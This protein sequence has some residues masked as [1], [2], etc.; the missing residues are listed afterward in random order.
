[1]ENNLNVMFFHGKTTDGYRFTIAGNINGN[2]LFMG[3]SICSDRDNFVKS[4][5]R[6]IATTRLLSEKNRSN[7][8]KTSFVIENEV[9]N[10]F[11]CFASL[12]AEHNFVPKKVLLKNFH[13]YRH[14]EELPF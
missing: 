5:G 6:S 2:H 3:I 13:L 12:A 11:K 10:E 7:L 8:G 14:K 9:D 1:M 4:R